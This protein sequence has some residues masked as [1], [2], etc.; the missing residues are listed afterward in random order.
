[1]AVR[2]KIVGGVL[3]TVAASGLMFATG[4]PAAAHV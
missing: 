3:A 2:R 1:V 4:A